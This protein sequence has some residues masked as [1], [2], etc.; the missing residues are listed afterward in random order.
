MN[1]FI[2]KIFNIWQHIV[3][4]QYLA[5]YSNNVKYSIHIKT[6]RVN[7]LSNVKERQ[8]ICVNTFTVSKTYLYV[9]YLILYLKPYSLYAKN[10]NFGCSCVLVCMCI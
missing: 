3:C 5:I 1:T 4:L 9:K 6:R 2:R 7:T 10:F 8:Y